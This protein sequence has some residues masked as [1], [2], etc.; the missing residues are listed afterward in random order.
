LVWVWLK[1]ILCILIIF[2]SGRAV[3]RYGD[4]IARRTGLGGVW[5]GVILL[6]LVTSL[7]EVFTGISAVT[8]VGAPDLTIGNLFGANAFNLLNLALLDI[9]YRNGSLLGAVSPVHRLTGW[10]SMALVLVAAVSIFISSRFSTMDIGWIGWYTPIIILLYLVFM[11]KI[12]RSEQRQLSSQT[13]QQRAEPVPGEIPMDRV[14]LYF[15]ITAAFIIG[16]G[17]WLAIIGD[18]I[19]VVTGWGKSFVGSLLIGFST[20]L[21]EITVSFA[22]MRMGALNMAVA[23]MIGSNLFNMTIIPIDDLFYWQGPV[24]ASVSV[25][26]LFTASMV[27]VMTG[28]FIAG[29][30]F[31][32]KRFLRLSWCNLTLIV[33]FLLQAYLSYTLA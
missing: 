25:N 26:H 5:I 8:L 12:F 3:A 32:P 31:K 27:V 16:A 28:I 1:F 23:N 33:L 13:T 4:I 20:T 21:P 7:P 2:F 24:L 6:A 29:L 10:L 14:Y 30:R 11:W 22:A 19:A 17:T 9:V 18:E 15:A